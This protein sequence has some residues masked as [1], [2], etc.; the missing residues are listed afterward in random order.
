MCMKSR[1]TT[2]PK[3]T[4]QSFGY[5]LSIAFHKLSYYG[6][7]SILF[8]LI[9][10]QFQEMEAMEVV[11][12][13]LILTAG[14]SV[15]YLIGGIIGD[16][17][18]GNRRASILGSILMFFGSLLTFIQPSLPPYLAIPLFVIG[19]VFYQPNLK[20]MYAKLYL[21]DTRLLDAG[22]MLLT[23]FVSIGMFFGAF[24]VALIGKY[25]GTEYGFL[26]V[27]ISTLLSLSMIL[28]FRK[29]E[30]P[31]EPLAQNSKSLFNKKA[32]KSTGIILA[33][34]ACYSFA[35]RLS[36]DDVYIE[37]WKVDFDF[38]SLF[39]HYLIDVISYVFYVLIGIALII[40][41]SR[42]YY[43][44]QRKIATSA[45]L[46]SVSFLL[47]FLF[48]TWGAVSMNIITIVSIFIYIL[49]DLLIEPIIQ[50]SVAKLMNRNYLAI[51]FGS[52][53]VLYIIVGYAFMYLKDVIQLL[54]KETFL[55][56]VVGFMLLGIILMV[57]NRKKKQQLQRKP[58][59]LEE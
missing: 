22:F 48:H 38:L 7:K 24:L 45:L 3:H 55:I 52:I 29:K 18:M 5:S 21:H 28:I 14:V 56:G 1:I 32:L 8:V 43:S 16:L 41:W 9:Y 11:S 27:S 50:S 34:L 19:C 58:V 35:W 53:G 2:S 25:F 49:G 57:K 51:G 13:A 12:F 26:A 54:T 4:V 20:A 47:A 10:D 31:A 17:W 15:S 37:Y 46:V 39:N 44:H 33:L 23:L 36:H 42:K 59:S 30:T 6:W 40:V